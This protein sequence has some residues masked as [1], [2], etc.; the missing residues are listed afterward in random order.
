MRKQV[1]D[2]PIFFGEGR[3]EESFPFPIPIV[4]K[5]P[6]LHASIQCI[7]I[8]PPQNAVCR[9][10]LA[11][12]SDVLVIRTYL[13]F[14]RSIHRSAE[15]C[16]FPSNYPLSEIIQNCNRVFCSDLFGWNWLDCQ[17]MDHIFP[18]HHA[19]LENR[20]NVNDPMEQ[21]Q[22]QGNSN[23]I[24]MELGQLRSFLA[25]I[26]FKRM[27]RRR[28]YARFSKTTDTSHTFENTLRILKPSNHAC[29]QVKSQSRKRWECIS[30]TLQHLNG[31]NIV[32]I[33]STGD[34]IVL[35][36][37][38]DRIPLCSKCLV[39]FSL[40]TNKCKEHLRGHIMDIE[41]HRKPSKRLLTSEKQSHCF[42]WYY[43]KRN[44]KRCLTCMKGAFE[45]TVHALTR[46]SIFDGL[47][48]SEVRFTDDRD[49]V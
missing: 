24:P 21:I 18:M 27:A 40:P 12:H 26:A 29:I 45:S 28:M 43:E 7:I 32:I 9:E 19:V 13:L 37:S 14:D 10:C 20:E 25:R 1:S 11:M 46:T 2:I 38:L 35:I 31:P 44:E 34:I 41:M 48:N 15:L 4:I 16:V 22:N 47:F 33:S 42:G 5:E 49:I 30:Y 3:N 17:E 39:V 23:Y 36:P 6:F 8:P